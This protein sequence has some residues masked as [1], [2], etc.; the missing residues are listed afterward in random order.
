[1]SSTLYTILDVPPDADQAAIVRAYAARLAMPEAAPD[2]AT[3]TYA[4]LVLS[5]PER[6]AAYDVALEQ[7]ARRHKGDDEM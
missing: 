4:Y 7:A 6:R 2:R 3:L 5:D 1:M